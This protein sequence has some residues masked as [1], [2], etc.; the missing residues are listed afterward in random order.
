MIV[1]FSGPFVPVPG[2]CNGI[3]DKLGTG[4]LSLLVDEHLLPLQSVLISFYK[5]ILPSFLKKKKKKK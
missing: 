5:F 2:S 1:I 4:L 3:A